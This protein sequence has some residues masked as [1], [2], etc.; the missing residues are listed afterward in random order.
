ML[1]LL[2]L[3]MFLLLLMLLL[4]LLLV[5]VLTKFLHSRRTYPLS[6][7]LPRE[8]QPAGREACRSC[9]LRLDVVTVM[10]AEVSVS[11]CC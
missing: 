2:L 3:L 11:G 5:S 4:L 10:H 1:P 7:A 8:W 6:A 9:S